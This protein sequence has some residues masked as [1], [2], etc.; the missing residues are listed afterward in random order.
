MHIG[1]IPIWLL[2]CLFGLSHATE[3]ICTAALPAMAQYFAISD[4]MAQLASSIYFIGFALGILIFGR[5][6]DISGRRPLVILGLII[7]SGSSILSAFATDIELIITLRFLQGFGASIG[8]VLAQAMARDSFDGHKLADIYVSIAISLAFV[9][10][11]GLIIGGYIVE[12]R[13]WWGNFQFLSILGALLCLACYKSLPETNRYIGNVE[14]ISYSKIFIRLLKDR[15]VMLYAF[16]VGSIS[17]LTMGF[18]VEAPF[19]FINVIGLSASQYGQIGIGIAAAN[20]AGGIINKYLVHRQFQSPTIIMLGLSLIVIGSL[21]LLTA[22][23][24]INDLS[25]LGA[26]FLILFPTMMHAIGHTFVM[27]HILHFALEDYRKINGSAGAIF[28]SLYYGLVA[29]ISYMIARLHDYGLTAF[30]SLFVLLALASSVAYGIIYK[31]N[32]KA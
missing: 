3:R 25:R 15:N 13:G 14:S 29:G 16:I 10:A 28:G 18:Y 32:T 8:S 30:S 4:D 31:T 23:T 27:P 5:L 7:Y 24:F 20:L 6:S 21:L 17:G 2:L 1:P 26:I 11:L 12:Y 19:I 22:M 9:P